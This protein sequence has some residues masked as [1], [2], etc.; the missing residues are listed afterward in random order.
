MNEQAQ[1][2]R[3]ALAALNLDVPAAALDRAAA[4]AVSEIEIGS[5]R[6]VLVTVTGAEWVTVKASPSA[7]SGSVGALARGV[8]VLAGVPEGEWSPVYGEPLGWV[9][10]NMVTR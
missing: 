7:S 3:D 5:R 8:Q 4:V 9:K 2:I 10:E 1:A 6:P